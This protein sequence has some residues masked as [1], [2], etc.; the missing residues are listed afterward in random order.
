MLRLLE[1]KVVKTLSVLF[2]LTSRVLLHLPKRPQQLDVAFIALV[3][4]R[5]EQDLLGI[6]EQARDAGQKEDTVR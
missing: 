4:L 1:H 2:V 3:V 5:V 6:D